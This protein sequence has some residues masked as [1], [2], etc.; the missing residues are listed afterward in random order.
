M[1]VKKI[2]RLEFHETAPPTIDA[3][4]NMLKLAEEQGFPVVTPVYIRA[5][6][7]DLDHD[8]YFHATIGE[9]DGDE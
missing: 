3:L 4:F 1:E 2:F 6:V 5:G 9:E 7:D 8:Y